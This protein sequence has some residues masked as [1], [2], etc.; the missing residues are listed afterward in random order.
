MVTTIITENGKKIVVSGNDPLMWESAGAKNDLTGTIIRAH[1]ARSGTV[2]Y[3]RYEWSR[4]EGYENTHTLLS[5]REAME[6]L[7]GKSFSG[8]MEENIREYLP[9]FFQEDA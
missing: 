1:K 6:S 2:Y 8:E 7:A 3:Y 9:E 4:W 5:A